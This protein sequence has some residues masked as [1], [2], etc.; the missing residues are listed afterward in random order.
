VP[1]AHEFYGPLRV[2]AEDIAISRHLMNGRT[3][4]ESNI[5][6]LFSRVFPKN[7]NIID[8]GANLGLH[9]IALAKLACQ[10]E[11]VYAFE[12]H[13]EILPLLIYNT[14]EYR[15]IRCFPKAASD[16]KA[17][18]HMPSVANSSNSDGTPLSTSGNLES[19]KVESCTIDSLAL[20]NIGLMKIDVEGHEMSCIRGAQKTIL[21]DHPVLIVEICGGHSLETAEPSI[22]AE[23]VAR[24]DEIC[25]LGYSMTTVGYH[26]YLFEPI[27]RS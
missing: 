17:I 26:D 23:I 25:A 18:F 19:Y 6:D 20:K 24:I 12:P 11:R 7:R 8:A 5:V 2:F 13:P 14:R 9:S 22:K 3:I 21:R 1:I 4:W 10:G 27:V 16:R 15:N